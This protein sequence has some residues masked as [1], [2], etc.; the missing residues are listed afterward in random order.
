LSSI[1]TDEKKGKIDPDS[2]GFSG[3]T[4]PIDIVDVI[5]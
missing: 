4:Q 5:L 2:P 1:I 3:K